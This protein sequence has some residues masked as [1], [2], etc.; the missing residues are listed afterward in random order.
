MRKDYVWI[1]QIAVARVSA[2][3]VRQIAEGIK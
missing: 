1:V 3:R 2:S